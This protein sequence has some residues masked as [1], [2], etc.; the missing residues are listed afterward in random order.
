MASRARLAGC[1]VRR[2]GAHIVRICDD[3]AVIA[4]LR[5]QQVRHNGG[6]RSQG[7]L[8]PVTAGA[9]ICETM[10]MPAPASIP[11]R[12]GSSS[13]SRSSSS[14]RS[15]T[16]V[17]RWES[18]SVLPWPGEVLQAGQHAALLQAARHGGDHIGRRRR[19]RC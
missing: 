2:D 13:A 1:I 5:A 15:V 10:I 8:S 19:D 6:G 12:K 16:D 3:D 14:V 17:P 4:Q 18:A 11:A 9:D 7:V